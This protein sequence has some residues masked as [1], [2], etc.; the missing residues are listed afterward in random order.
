MYSSHKGMRD[1]ALFSIVNTEW[2]DI[3]ARL[4][5]RLYKRYIDPTNEGEAEHG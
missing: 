3:K 2:P 5:Q 4:E 1:V